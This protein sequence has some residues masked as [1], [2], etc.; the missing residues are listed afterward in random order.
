MASTEDIY[1]IGVGMTPFGKMLDRS[2]KSLV[3]Q[4]VGEA[5]EDAGAKSSDLQIAYYANTSQGV[6]DGQHLVRGQVALRAMG[7][8]GLPVVN[9]ENAC[10]S[11]STALQQAVAF[12][13]SGA[14]DVALAVGA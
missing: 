3:A 9:V 6:M 12:L 14:A 13:K 10:A 8:G 4:A 5:L 1:L 2:V 7:I 11:S